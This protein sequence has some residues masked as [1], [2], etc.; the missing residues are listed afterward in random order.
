MMNI[1]AGFKSNT[2]DRVLAPVRK[3]ILEFIEPDMKVLEVGCGTGSLLF[4]AAGKI[5]QGVGI[6]ID[7]SMIDFANARKAR[8]QVTNLI[9]LNDD[10]TAVEAMLQGGF[11]IATSTLCLHEMD[12]KTAVIALSLMARYS[13]KIIIADYTIPKTIGKKI[14][15]EVDEFLS[16]HYARFK[17][18]RKNGAIWHLAKS[19]NIEIEKVLGTPFDGIDIWVLTGKYHA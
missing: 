9:F 14:S 13:A 8:E 4:G 6:D 18:Y 10:L 7:K 19:A 1:K 2:A 5:N 12:E 15:I 17:A 3:K 11:D 16:G